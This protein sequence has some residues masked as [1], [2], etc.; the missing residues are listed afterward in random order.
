MR[1]MPTS[2]GL[3]EARDV[4]VR[5]GRTVAIEDV[6]LRIEE[7]EFVGLVGPNG[8]GKSTLVRTLLGLVEPTEGE[9][10][11]CGEPIHR[12]DDWA[13]VGYVPQDAIHVD[14]GFPA[15]A[16]EVALLGRVAKRGLLRRWRSE[17]REAARRALETVGVDHLED[18]R[19]GTLSGGERQRVFLAKALATDPDLLLLDEPMAG[20]DPAAREAFYN[21]IDGLNHDEDLTILLV[22][23]D[24]QAVQMCCHRLVAL[25]QRIVYDGSPEG[26][27]EAGGLSKAY[28]MHIAHHPERT[29][30]SS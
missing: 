11:C 23:H 24:L 22:S 16:L 12:F 4:D 15:S 1:Q 8:S 29:E 9:V 19:V 17:D 28:D 25:N 2:E 20:I 21:L 10:C 14:P 26:F 6:S 5:Y 27:E 7:G 18:R 3:L 13:R 30:G